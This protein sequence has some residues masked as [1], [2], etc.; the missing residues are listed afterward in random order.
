MRRSDGRQGFR[1]EQ[2]PELL[3]L[4]R[5]DEKGL[6]PGSDRK[7]L[8]RTRSLRGEYDDPGQWPAGRPALPDVPDQVEA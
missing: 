6:D 1:R 3:R 2:V 8:V 5:L 4:G 7:L